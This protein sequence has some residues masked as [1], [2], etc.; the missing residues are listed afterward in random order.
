MVEECSSIVYTTENGAIAS[1]WSWI[2]CSDD[3][4]GEGCWVGCVNEFW[5]YVV[6]VLDFC[7]DSLA[8]NVCGNVVACSYHRRP[9]AVVLFFPLRVTSYASVMVVV[10]VVILEQQ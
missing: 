4:D 5:V 1:C 6:A 7:V 2:L 10:S 3:V 9:I 8:V